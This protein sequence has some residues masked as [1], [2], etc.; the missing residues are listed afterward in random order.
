MALESKTDIQILG[1]TYTNN[2][3]VRVLLSGLVQGLSS[4]Y[5]QV[6]FS[7]LDYGHTATTILEHTASGPVHIP[8][9]NLRFS[10]RLWLPNNIFSIGLVILAS[11]LL[12]NALRD[13][14]RN[15]HP[16][17]RAVARAKVNI[18]VSG[19]DSFS[20]IY[21]LRR[22]LYVAL[23]QMIAIWLRRPLV[24]APQTFGPFNS[25]LSRLFARY[26]IKRSA[27]VYSRDEQGAQAL[28][29]LLPNSTH[30]IRVI[31]DV[32]FFMEPEPLPPEVKATLV[33]WR[34]Q[35]PIFGLNVSKLLWMGGYTEKNMFGL[36]EDYQTL[37]RRIIE[38]CVTELKIPVLLIPHVYGGPESSESE[39]VLCRDLFSE[40]SP[41]F[42]RMVG[43]LDATLS[44]REVKSLIGT[45]DVFAGGR[46]HACIAA[47]SQG[48]PTVA[49]AYS[50]KFAGVM[51]LVGPEIC[52][53]DLRALSTTEILAKVSDAVR[54]RI[55]TARSLRASV[56]ALK[57]RIREGFRDPALLSLLGAPPDRFQ[58]MNSENEALPE[59]AQSEH[60]KAHLP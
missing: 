30:K 18:A 37:N 36:A 7:L 14:L 40:F 31:P 55:E 6:S 38:H 42:P 45:C 5:H 20:D 46:M 47:V 57:T 9:I 51:E 13:A 10:W 4:S 12:P 24:Q 16:W 22:L 34:A 23:P 50:D 33:A 41:R 1:I 28:T 48:V 27:L 44:H 15:R 2:Y 35:R 53:A 32:G 52:V 59:A 43:F 39:L 11:E 25:R 60:V 56:R 54:A 58:T 3:G 26:I 19:G 21:G 49:L 29:E 8:F 17:I